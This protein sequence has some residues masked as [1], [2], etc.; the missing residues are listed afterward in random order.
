MAWKDACRR[1]TQGLPPLLAIL[2]FVHPIARIF[3]RWDWRLDL[4]SHF[5]EP[6][7][8]I[9]LLAIVAM[10]WTRRRSVV[11]LLLMAAFQVEPVLRYSVGNPVKPT[12]PDAPRLRI[13][14]ANVLVDNHDHEP[15]K[16]LIRETKP[17]IVGL[18]EVSDEWVAG[19]EDVAKEYPYRFD[20]P[21]GPRG[22]ALWFKQPPIGV[23]PPD[24]LT[25]EGWP[26]IRA[27][28]TFAGETRRLWLV[29]PAS[30]MRRLGRD[31]GFP[32]LAA[33]AGRIGAEGGSTI[34][35]GDM[36]TTDGSPHFRDFARVAGLRDSRLGFGRQ[37]SWPVGLPYQI[38]IDH[39]FLSSDLAVVDRIPG[40]AIGSD[41][42]PF[43][44]I[45]AP[46]AKAL[47]TRAAAIS[48]SSR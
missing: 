27:T 5:Q 7:L 21:D 18:V 19:L 29:H 10:L 31:R 2:A 36:N 35:L 1:V 22:L 30:P 38:T 23:N 40:P 46:S 47:S 8:V 28:F 42:R 48:A 12:S 26:Y 33:L 20:F 6:A 9:T 34:V 32:E 11:V 4:L 13:L 39:A 17:D 25:D 43:S 41:H 44:L 16:R 3:A 15:L 45:V 37:A 14:M 24:R